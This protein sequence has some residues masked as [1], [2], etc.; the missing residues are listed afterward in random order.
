MT[1]QML[2]K[3]R[4]NALNGNYSNVEFRKE[5]IEENIQLKNNTVD[6]VIG[7]CVINLTTNKTNVFKEVFRVLKNDRKMVIS[8]LTTDDV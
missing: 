7:N 3:A 1:D 2:E 4:E 8:D 5:Y 6:A